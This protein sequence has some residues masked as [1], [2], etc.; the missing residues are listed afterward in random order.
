MPLFSIHYATLLPLE[1][2]HSDPTVSNAYDIRAH[3]QRDSA[4][5][6]KD[7]PVK[8]RILRYMLTV[9]LSD[10]D[11]HKVIAAVA[12]AIAS[13]QS[14]SSSSAD[15]VEYSTDGVDSDIT[16]LTTWD[17]VSCATVSTVCTSY[18]LWPDVM[19]MKAGS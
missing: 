8:I 1:L 19:C 4:S 2:A 9:H 11:G 7:T 16:A 15:R 12:R 6:P 14:S 10:S 3:W 18:V 13:S 5:F 17:L